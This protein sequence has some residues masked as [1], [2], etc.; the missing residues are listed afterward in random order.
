[1]KTKIILSAL[2][3]AMT[4]SLTGCGGTDNS[5][6]NTYYYTEITDSYNTT[7]TGTGT[8]T[9]TTTEP[10]NEPTLV[11]SLITEN[12]TLFKANSPY[13]LTGSPTVV[14]NGSILTIEPGVTI[15]GQEN[16]YL[17]IAKGS[18]IIADGTEEAPIIFTSEAT[19][20]TA[21][22]AL[23]P[24]LAPAAAGQWGG[25]VLL[26]KAI[27]N[28]ANL[29]F[30]VDEAN[31][32]FAYGGTN[33]ADNS[34]I[35]RNVKILNSGFAVAPDKEV[36]GLSL[37]G[38][39]SETIVD[40]ITVIDSADDGIEIWGGSVNLN[41]ISI[42]GAQDDGF[43]VD[44]GYHGT[45]KNLTVTQTEPGSALIEM[46]NSGDATLQRTEWTLDG[47]T[48]QASNKQ[49]GEGG[50]YFK[51]ADV[52]IHASNGTINMTD[53]NASDSGLHNKK[54]VYSGSTL[55]N[56]LVLGSATV[57]NNMTSGDAAGVTV[58]DT[59]VEDGAGNTFARPTI[60]PAGSS[61]SGDIIEDTLL[62][63]ANSPYKLAG[64]KVKVKNGATLIIEPGVTVYGESTAYLIITKGSKINASGTATDPIIFTSEAAFNGATGVS[65]QWGGVTILG[66]AITNEPDTI[67]YEVDE[68]DADF[69]YGGTN[70]ADNSGVLNYVKILNSGFAV[71]PDK[72]VNGLSLCGVG[73]STIVDNITVL[74]SGDDG[75]EIW[76]GA[77]NL[78]NI[79]ITG[80]EDDGLDLDSGYHGTVKNL[81]VT[82]VAP[83]A[84]LIEMTNHGDATKQRTNWTLDGFTLTASANQV[85]EGGI[86]FKD[87][88]VT[89]TIK[90]GTVDMTASPVANKAAGLTNSSGVFASPVFEN[91][92]VK[93]NQYVNVVANKKDGTVSDLGTATLNAAFDANT[94]NTYEA[95][96]ETLA[97]GSD[98][99]G[100][101]T[102]NTLLTKA[103]SPYKLAGNKV[104]IKNNSILKIEPGVTIY[105]ES[106]AYLIVTKGSKINA[107]GTQAEPIIFTSEAAFNGAT[108]VA[109]QWGGVTI[110]GQAITNEPDTIR[111]EV[112]EADA[113]FAYGGTNDADNSG[114]L[115][116]VQIL[117]SGYAVAP[118][119]EV[120]GLSLCAVGSGTVVDNI[121][122]LD[123]GDD[124][125]EIWGGSVNLNNISVTGAQDD[126]FDVDSGYHGTVTNLAVTQTEPG[127]ALIEMTNHGDATKQRTN[128]TLDGF[129]LTAS[130][131]QAA[132]GGIYFKDLDVTATIKNGTID[133]TASPV[134][135]KA[136]GLTNSAGV[137]Y[138]S[139]VLENVKIKGSASVDVAANKKDGTT[140]DAG[141]AT[142]NAALDAD[143]TNTFTSY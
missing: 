41:N 62:T 68:S 105:G 73:S 9:N 103:N 33:D 28:E 102:V 32:D 91:V 125:I 99:T 136:A 111:Y 54:G 137:V 83:G 132:E 98:L 46:T 59:I 66:E 25:V 126:G 36:N 120:N 134:A 39:G 70:D 101:I 27:V 49:V 124:G 12:T 127:F 29:F 82:Q 21:A 123:S 65:G 3:A 72:E 1:M 53:S 141:T 122:V 87:L 93:G 78:N 85:G 76:G 13:L 104:K 116:Y 121:T 84:A 139:P 16:S 108:G 97:Q 115:N 52:A 23:A 75:I 88:D 57:D 92:T 17:V 26:G 74:N 114:V 42:T 14:K 37:C 63:K 30:E 40:N 100:D 89:A 64:N 10:T 55:E 47:F 142:L 8:D 94:T 2:A 95:Y 130:A 129:T 58:L 80:A 117:N 133:M 128:W 43:D 38:V 77:V 131:N 71:A 45:V 34:G 6:T 69:A 19:M 140:A 22:P 20:P 4:A 44:N 138:A 48:L 86:Y 81:A 61:L 35:L 51:D 143:V 107:N 106:L 119:K 90:N 15:Y 96:Y 11:S 110:L 5:S 113:D 118:D 56:I 7:N 109:G 31:P 79:S 112:D 60:L 67:R 18:K 24:S 135:N 50:I